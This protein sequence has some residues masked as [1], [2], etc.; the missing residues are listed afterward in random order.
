MFVSH[1]K[2]YNNLDFFIYVFC[3][4]CTVYGALHLYIFH[5][6]RKIH[7]LT[8]KFD[9]LGIKGVLLKLATG[10]RILGREIEFIMYDFFIS[11]D[12]YHLTL[13]LIV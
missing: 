3:V 4:L 10:N 6:C 5:K 1:A 11:C 7:S 13:I 8:I 2:Q 12:I 9:G